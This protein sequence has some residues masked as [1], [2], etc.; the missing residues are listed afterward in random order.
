MKI[1]NS[2]LSK[3]I[4]T[5]VFT[6]FISISFAQ[7]NVSVTINSGSSGTVCDD[8]IPP[9]GSNPGEPMSRV[10]IENY[11]YTYYLDVAETCVETYPYLQFTETYN[12]PSGFPSTLEVCLEAFE[13]DGVSCN[14]VTAC[15]VDICQNFALPAIGSSIDYDL[16]I[17]ND[18]NNQSWATINFTISVTGAFPPGYNNDAI[19]D[20]IDLGELN[21][22]DTL[23]NAGL[24]NYGNFC[25]T[26]AGEPSPWVGDNDQGV[27]FTFTTG[28]S[29]GTIMSI[30][31]NSDP[32]SFGN[33]IDL[34]LALYESSDDTCGGALSLI[35]EEYDGLGLFNDE[36]MD[37]SCLE[38]NKRY[39]LLVD[40]EYTAVI[41]TGGIEG[42]FG[43][44]ITDNGVS[45]NLAVNC[46]DI[47]V[48]LDAFDNATIVPEDIIQSSA[49]DCGNVVLS[50]SQT[51]FTTSDVGDVIVTLTATDAQGNVAT[52]D[53]T[54]TVEANT[55]STDNFDL[56]DI[57]IY[58]NPFKSSI[59]INMG[60]RSLDA[61]T[62]RL[63][64]INGRFIYTLN[65]DMNSSG[66]LTIG[67]LEGLSSGVY[68]LKI[69]YK[70]TNQTLSKKLFKF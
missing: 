20:A 65:Q 7:V 39:F 37:V 18:G 46:Q 22:G 33:D 11:G 44:A 63:Y 31:A 61:I 48:T 68:I 16:T 50:A 36:D 2:P 17:P 25:A 45:A 15:L 43:L 55:L 34:Q 56:E 28:S 3:V 49:S 4:L 10:N 14:P 12:C 69:E 27:W 6:L 67:N 40:G 54:V 64:D 29:L 24:N 38:P 62:L 5:L 32:Q 66:Q 42:Y 13:D 19:C 51:S 8:P 26:N 41:N 53:A 35:D 58:P 23:G 57:S 1:T 59:N 30:D 47:T 9:F 21:L 60:S 52:C 70:N